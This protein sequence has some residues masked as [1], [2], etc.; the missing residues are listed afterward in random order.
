MCLILM[1]NTRTHNLVLV[2]CSFG[3]QV[4][5]G[6]ESYNYKHGSQVADGQDAHLHSTLPRLL[7]TLQGLSLGA[8]AALQPALI[9]SVTAKPEADIVVAAWWAGQRGQPGPGH[10]S[11]QH[12]QLRDVWTHGGEIWIKVFSNNNNL[13][14]GCCCSI[15]FSILTEYFFCHYINHILFRPWGDTV[16][17]LTHQSEQ[18]WYADIQSQLYSAMQWQCSG[19]GGEHA[20]APCRDAGGRKHVTWTCSSNNV[21]AN[22]F[23]FKLLFGWIK[24]WYCQLLFLFHY[25]MCYQLNA[26]LFLHPP[27]RLRIRPRSDGG[28]YL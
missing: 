1:L 4:V 7:N 25:C 12:Q 13:I 3:K 19:R 22:V 8:G 5:L 9:Y 24:Y 11:P 27:R 20:S 14:K 28:K 17:G 10:G 6:L 21:T 18:L 2:P 16:L 26:T 23:Y 15:A